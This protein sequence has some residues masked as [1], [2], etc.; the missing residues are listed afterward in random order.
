LLRA[1][2]L[3][4]SLVEEFLSDTNS[5]WLLG[6]P[7]AEVAEELV[8]CHPALRSDEVRAGVKPT[9][10]AGVWRVTLAS[11][12]RPGF[13]ARTAGILTNEGLEIT[14]AAGTVLPESRVAVLRLTVSSPR[15]EEL[16]NEDWERIGAQ[17]RDLHELTIPLAWGRRGPVTVD[18]QPQGS[19]RAVVHIQG[20]DGP[21][22]LHAVADALVKQGCEVEACRCGAEDGIVK[23]LF[24]VTGDLDPAALTLSLSG[25]PGV[26]LRSPPVPLRLG[27]V[28]AYALVV[29]PW[30]VAA[31]IW[32][33][34]T[35]SSKP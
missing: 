6:V 17:L 4:P 27:A 26:A 18:A 12:D 15:L 34:L 14:H 8:L 28:V 2:S 22:L 25:E 13:L 24:V 5:L 35:G 1:T 11:R 21:G 30:K 16:A 29:L 23:D 20:P 19:G 10:E 3:P 9:D 33:Q 32:R 31:G 7:D